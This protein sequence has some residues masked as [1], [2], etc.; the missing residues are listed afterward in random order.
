MYSSHF[1][2]TPFVC[3]VGTFLKNVDMWCF[4]QI[5]KW[6]GDIDNFSEAA[7]NNLEWYIDCNFASATQLEQPKLN[8]TH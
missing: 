3:L 6:V 8:W 7:W 1:A 5:T 2:I 4:L